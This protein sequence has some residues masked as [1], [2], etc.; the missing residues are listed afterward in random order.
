MIQTKL[1][2]PLCGTRG[3]RI[4]EKD[5]STQREPSDPLSCGNC[6]E[7]FDNISNYTVNRI[8]RKRR[9]EYQED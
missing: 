2:C 7:S 3:L 8:K 6:G 1:F 5:Y 9:K 4:K